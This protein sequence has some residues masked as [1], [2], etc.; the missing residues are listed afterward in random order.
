MGKMIILRKG[1]FLWETMVC[2][3]E[4]LIEIKRNYSS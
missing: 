1:L 4:S 2:R 3:V